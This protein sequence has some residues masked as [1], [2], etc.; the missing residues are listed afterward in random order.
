MNSNLLI[1]V[2]E[3]LRRSDMIQLF[4]AFIALLILVLAVTWPAGSQRVN[5]SWYSLVQAR[6]IALV[7]IA[8]SYGEMSALR[9]RFERASVL[10]ALL[11]LALFSLPLEIASYA[12]SFPEV[13]L[14]WSLSIVPANLIAFFG[15]GLTLGRLLAFLRIRFLSPLL[16][17]LVLLGVVMIDSWL[18]R[19]VFNPFLAT[20]TVVPLHLIIM[21]VLAAGTILSL[22]WRRNKNKEEG[23]L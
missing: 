21:L 8:F 15:V 17:P 12:A 3:R 14:L 10:L 13:P 16:I 18:G 23:P 4:M 20:T 6:V 2:S 7:L 19:T 11:L 5:D 1:A 9:S 22:V